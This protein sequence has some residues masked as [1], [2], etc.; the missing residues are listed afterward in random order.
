VNIS[1][2][3]FQTFFSLSNY[4]CPCLVCAVCGKGRAYWL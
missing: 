1:D 4:I 3:Y 2:I